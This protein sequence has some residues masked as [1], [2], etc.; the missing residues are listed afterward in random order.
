MTVTL[1]PYAETRPF[2]TSVNDE[3]LREPAALMRALAGMGF[4]RHLTTFARGEIR[5]WQPDYIRPTISPSGTVEQQESFAATRRGEA[6]PVNRA[7]RDATVHVLAAAARP[8]LRVGPDGRTVLHTATL[9]FV[10]SY[11]GAWRSA[12]GAQLGEDLISL[13]ML[14]WGCRYAQAAGRVA[15]LIGLEEIPRLAHAG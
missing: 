1:H 7:M 6:A 3:A 5:W 13:G 2:W 4:S 11:G 14:R 10:D 12:D 9:Y 15:R 8:A